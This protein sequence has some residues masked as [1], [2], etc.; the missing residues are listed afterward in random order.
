MKKLTFPFLLL[1]A[2]CGTIVG[3]T[4]QD[5]SFDSNVKGVK[6]FIDGVE[7]CKT[8]CPCA[9]RAPL[10]WLLPPEKFY[11]VSTLLIRSR[12]GLCRRSRDVTTVS[13][14]FAATAPFRSAISARKPAILR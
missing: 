10:R 11:L 6:I 1:S 8:P 7:V 2:A 12:R 5:I 3:G 13:G 14:C 4:S 9:E